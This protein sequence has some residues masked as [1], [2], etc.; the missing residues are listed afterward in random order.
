M[1][2][3]TAQIFSECDKCGEWP[4]IL[5]LKFIFVIAEGNILDFRF[6][7]VSTN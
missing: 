2:A 3:N 1:G 4:R 6:K 5:T 7:E